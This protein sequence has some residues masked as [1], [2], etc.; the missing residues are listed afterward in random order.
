MMFCICLF[1]GVVLIVV[2]FVFQMGVVYVQE[3]I[4]KV[5]VVGLLMGGGVVYGKDIEN[6]VCMVVDEVNVVCMMVGGKL[7]KF[8]IVLQDDQSDLCIGVQVVQ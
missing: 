3:M 8:V 2:F 1:F 7:V 6:G 5:G 4:V